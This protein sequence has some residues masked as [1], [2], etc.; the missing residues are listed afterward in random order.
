M[1]YERL[2]SE[3][4]KQLSPSPIRELLKIAV[5]P[6]MISLAGGNPSPDTFPVKELRNCFLEVLEKDWKRILQ[7][8][9]TEGNSDLIEIIKQYSRNQ[10]IDCENENILVTTGSQQGMDLVCKVL[11]NP[12]DEVIVEL[13]S[14]PG[15]IHTLRSY[16][17]KLTG[18]PV[19]DEG[20]DIGILEEILQE[21]QKTGKMPKFIY[22]IP[23]FQNPSGVTLTED[24]R[25]SILKLAE[26][27][28]ITI[29]EDDPYNE[30]RYDGENIKPIKAMDCN[31]NVI[32]MSSFSKTFCPG[33]RVA[34]VIG[35]KDLVRKMVIGK[36]GVDLHTSSLN[37]AIV[38]EYCR[39]N[40]ME[41]HIK[42]ILLYYKEKRDIMLESLEMHFKN[43]A[44]WTRPQGGFFIW[45]SLKKNVDTGE[46]FSKAVEKG[47]VY[48]PGSSFCV[49][50]SNKNSMRLSFATVSNENI[51][52]GIQLLSDIF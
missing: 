18:V 43:L 24:R 14:Y 3:R 38:A 23:T 12:G 11:L 5:K 6:G 39:N 9:P 47:V 45:V 26:L 37:Q 44:T 40:F 13:P 1:N 19:D 36:Q 33:V 34:W 46:L 41:S 52:K 27:Y 31:E 32:Y 48:V 22:I 35:Q 2:Y 51:K 10:G 42:N 4:I 49:D 28:G 30:L 17:A 7:Y 50:G 20:I 29:V 8:S 16:Q 25:K 15:S 21:R